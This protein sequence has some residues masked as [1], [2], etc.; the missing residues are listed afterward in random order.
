MPIH[1]HALHQFSTELL[2]EA[3]VQWLEKVA[4][5]DGYRIGELNYIFCSDE[6]LLKINQDFLKHDT[7]TDIITFDYV[8]A[9]TLS[10]DIYI[11]TERVQEN[12]R[13]LEQDF[14]HELRRV[15]V[16]GLLHL[17]G[18]GDKNEEEKTSMRRAEDRC[19]DLRFGKTA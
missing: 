15:M 5:D 14:G 13:T 4:Q 11:S 12:A 8:V 6:Q 3:D 17:L 1:F 19:L 18:M 2:S 16:H 10:G 7:Y 9:Q